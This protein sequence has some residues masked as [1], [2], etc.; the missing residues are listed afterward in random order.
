MELVHPTCP[1]VFKAIHRIPRCNTLILRN[2]HCITDKSKPITSRFGKSSKT[3]SVLLSITPA[4]F[5]RKDWNKKSG[6]RTPSKRGHDLFLLVLS[7][8]RS[9]TG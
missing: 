1:V 5:E 2:T 8:S 6:F 3:N 7:L 4:T 9:V